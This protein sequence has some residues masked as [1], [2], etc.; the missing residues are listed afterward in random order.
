MYY[1]QKI[2]RNGED[3]AVDYLIKKGYTILE[4][5]FNCWYGEI[6]I[7]ALDKKEVVFIEVKTR[8]NR[9]YGYAI[10]AVN[11]IKKKHLWK[12]V[13]YYVYSRNLENEFIRID[14]VE[15]YIIKGKLKINHIKNAIN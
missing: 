2:G 12:S 1:K 13:E 11:N 4:R 8:T 3:I 6:D 7:I 9:N 15:V 5:N 10:E 14:I